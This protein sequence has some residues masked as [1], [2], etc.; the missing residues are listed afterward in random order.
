MSNLLNDLRE[1]I[2]RERVLIV[3]GTGVSIGATGG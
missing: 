1:E 3:V 2:A